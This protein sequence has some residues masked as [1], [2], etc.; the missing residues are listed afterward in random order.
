MGEGVLAH[1][2]SRPSQPRAP[3]QLTKTGNSCANC[4]DCSS[5]RTCTTHEPKPQSPKAQTHPVTQIHSAMLRATFLIAK[6]TLPPSSSIMQLIPSNHGPRHSSQSQEINVRTLRTAQTARTERTVRTT[7]TTR[8]V[9][10]A[11]TAPVAEIAQCPNLNLEAQRLKATPRHKSLNLELLELKKPR[12][13]G[14]FANSRAIYSSPHKP[15]LALAP[16]S[17]NSSTKFLGLHFVHT[18]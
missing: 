17:H 1:P 7:R 10:T 16:G 18:T 8:T 12:Q 15:L 13:R 11:R 9:R 6:T 2:A 5:G 3:A 4:A 14:K